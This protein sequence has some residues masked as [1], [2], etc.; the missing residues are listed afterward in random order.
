MEA[1]LALIFGLLIGSFL[2][3]CI[4][5]WPRG[6]SVV[7]P[8]SHCVRCRKTL[9][10]YDNIPV[11]SYVILGGACRYCGK[12]ISLRYPT[13]ELMTGLLW[14]FFVWTLGPT[15]A[16]F[17]MCIFTAM[18]VALVFSDLEKRILP[19]ELTLGGTLIGL[20]FSA[21]VPVPDITSQAL[22]WL[23]GG[24]TLE[25]R[26]H[27]VAE[28]AIGALLPAAFL[29]GGG[30]LYYKVRGREG[31]GLGDVKL[32]AMVGS[33]LGLRGALLTLI[34]GSLSGSFI[35]YGY[36]KVTG[37]D[38]GKYELPF[39]TFLGL[40]ALAAAVAG[41]RILGWYSSL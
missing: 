36:I 22:L 35:G 24:I 40:S 33:F 21:F 31:L 28:S 5:R 19:D 37:Q 13:V 3:V 39:G 7:K 12:R 20:G 38:P 25:G 30:W 11:V 17:K 6:R 18:L 41:Q 8:R 2:N 34:L 15:P 14:F 4:H 1:I 26:P 23:I 32:I 29:Y 9:A 16:A 10:W 27:W